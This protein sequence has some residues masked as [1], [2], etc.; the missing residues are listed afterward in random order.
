MAKPILILEALDGAEVLFSVQRDRDQPWTI[1]GFDSQGSPAAAPDAAAT[2]RINRVVVYEQPDTPDQDD[3]SAV[4]DFPFVPGSTSLLV[5]ARRRRVAIILDGLIRFFLDDRL[6]GWRG[7][8]G[9]HLSLSPESSGSTKYSPLVVRHA[10]IEKFVSHPISTPILLKRDDLKNKFQ[11]SGGGD[12]DPF[13][14]PAFGLPSGLVTASWTFGLWSTAPLDRTPAL[15]IEVRLDAGYSQLYW[16]GLFRPKASTLTDQPSPLAVNGITLVQRPR[17]SVEEWYGSN[18]SRPLW[19]IQLSLGDVTEQVAAVYRDFVAAP[20]HRASHLVKDGQPLSLLP[21]LDSIDAN[22]SVVW[23]VD[24]TIAGE[25]TTF[26]PAQA[27]SSDPKKLVW[28]DD[29]RDQGAFRTA[30][31]SIHPAVPDE[32]PPPA[33]AQSRPLVVARFPCFCTDGRAGNLPAALEQLFLL[34]P[35][36][37]PEYQS[38]L[39]VV[40]RLTAVTPAGGDGQDVRLGALRLSFPPAA[41]AS[42]TTIAGLEDG[43]VRFGLTSD[44]LVGIVPVVYECTLNIGLTD[45][46]PSGQDPLPGEEFADLFQSAGDDRDTTLYESRFRREPPLVVEFPTDRSRAGSQTLPFLL[47]ARETVLTAQSQTV[48]L[49]LARFESSGRGAAATTGERHRLWV[50]DRQPFLIAEIRFDDFLADLQAGTTNEIANF[51][52]RSGSAW[53]MSAAA[54]GFDLVLPPQGVG[55]AAEKYRAVVDPNVPHD[56]D[57]KTLVAYRFTP[58]AVLRVQPSYYRQRF[59]EPPWNLRRLLGYP[60][61]R[62]PGMALDEIRFELLYGLSG[63]VTAKGL[64]LAELAARLGDI[65]GR[66]PAEPLWRPNRDQRQG[67]LRHREAWSTWYELIQTRLSVL[68]PWRVGSAGPDEPDEKDPSKTPGLALTDGVTYSLRPS[69][70]LAFPART[71]ATGEGIAA[72]LSLLRQLAPDVPPRTYVDYIGESDLIDKVGKTVAADILSEAP[73]TPLPGGVAW[74][75]ESVNLY[76]LFWSRPDADA[77]AL[78]RPYFSSLG[79]WGFQKATFADGQLRIYSDTAM[80]RT[81]SMTLEILG[82]I[83]VTWHLAKLVIVYERTVLPT[84]QFYYTETNP[85]QNEQDALRGRPVLRKVKE[86][87]ELIEPVRQFPDDGSAPVERGCV[88][89]VGFPATGLR[90][91]VSSRWGHDVGKANDPDPAAAEGWKVPLWVP[92]AQPEDV[93]P[94]PSLYALF[95]PAQGDA[96][97]SA[98]IRDPQKLFFFTNTKKGRDPDPHKWPPVQGIDFGW[99][100][101]EAIMAP[102]PPKSWTVDGIPESGTLPADDAVRG[103]LGPFTFTL[104]PVS[105]AVD[106]MAERVAQPVGAALRNVT[107][108]R[109]YCPPPPEVVKFFQDAGNT[110]LVGLRDRVDAGLAAAREWVGRTTE[111]IGARTGLDSAADLIDEL[112]DQAA[113]VADQVKNLKLPKP[114]QLCDRLQAQVRRS[115]APVRA[116][117]ETLGDNFARQTLA[118]VDQAIGP[119]PGNLAA[120]IQKLDE[121]TDNL[122]DEWAGQIV[123]Q[124][125]LAALNPDD[126]PWLQAAV[127]DVRAAGDGIVAS[128]DEFL[129]GLQDLPLAVA[130]AATVWP[131]FVVPFHTARTAVQDGLARLQDL[132]AQVT[133]PIVGELASALRVSPDV[134]TAWQVVEDAARNLS[135]TKLGDL[136]AALDAVDQDAFTTALNNDIEGDIEAARDA[137][138]AAWDTLVVVVF[139]GTQAVSAKLKDWQAKASAVQQA[140]LDKAKD[141]WSA[142]KATLQGLKQKFTTVTEFRSALQR[143]LDTLRNGWDGVVQ[144]IEDAAADKVDGYCKD[145]LANVSDYI[146]FV[147]WLFGRDRLKEWAAD[148][149]KHVPNAEDVRRRLAGLEQELNNALRGLMDRAADGLLAPLAKAVTAAGNSVFR[150]IRAFGEAP[151]VPGLDFRLPDFQLATVTDRLAHIGYYFSQLDGVDLGRLIPLPKVDIT[152]VLAKAN[153]LGRDVLNALEIKLPTNQLFDR[154]VPFDLQK[155]DL[156]SIFPNFAGLKLDDLFEGLK[157]PATATDRVRVTH[158]ADPQSLRGWVQIDAD[159]PFSDPVTLFT[160]AGVQ[161]RILGGRFQATSRIEGGAGQGARQTFRGTISGDWEVAVGGFTLVTITQTALRFDDSGRITFDVR[162]DNVRLPGPMAWLAD[163]ISRFNFADQGFSFKVDAQG[164]HVV[165]DL[166]LPNIQAGTFGLAN[167]RLGFFFELAL[168]QGSGGPQFAITS[169][170]NVARRQAPFTLTVFILGGA[171]WFDFRFHYAPGQKEL[172][173][174]V[175][176]GILASASLAISLGPVSGGVYAY[177]GVVVEYSA[178]QGQSADLTV[179]L[180]IMFNGRLSVLGIVSVQLEVGLDADYSTGG[181]LLGRGHVNVSIPICWCFTLKVSCSVSYRFG[182]SGGSRALDGSRWGPLWRPGSFVPDRRPWDG[183]VYPG[184]EDNYA[185]RAEMFVAMFE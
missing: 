47:T 4:V 160:F 159:V 138:K 3:K 36:D 147:Q 168:S 19:L 61:E 114:D 68:E 111:V 123:R 102:D 89:G 71:T 121:L 171:G 107:L 65:P 82:R 92:G 119:L 32:D 164:V 48:D 105:Q 99:C 140:L 185:A 53:E 110:T 76:N 62:E 142:A 21:T 13:V 58:P 162:P 18:A 67:Y 87:V 45:V 106:V 73:G 74:P 98:D 183:P 80:G 118:R 115:F 150:L 59:A 70:R 129:D 51:S 128:I 153:E 84:R 135:G 175:T 156:R 158:G 44:N 95:Q 16:S 178:R 17:G 151:R 7:T 33:P 96:T 165:L 112:V 11:T 57:E 52:T 130:P 133:G 20:I 29:F 181:G 184:D 169:G 141:E 56:V 1:R 116:A 27:G 126:W 24:F 79:G 40:F 63:R 88:L 152:P 5:E 139:D 157:L 6:A 85:D 64:R 125:P 42:P 134:Q 120:G 10:T 50:I 55:E 176:V 78:H 94:R 83:S 108:M 66:Q 77:G 117:A 154:L 39:T 131:E 14:I 177:F 109:G 132:I 15:Q 163:L 166:P 113:A 30:V 148:V 41:A 137:L 25:W 167:L 12:W 179:S 143:E 173:A 127:A 90:I 146:G 149:L 81:H 26:Q 161:V 101:A 172:T 91:N 9:F 136:Q 86:Y 2:A 60:A 124:N 34:S 103:G 93:Y 49:I 31:G 97:V 180:V 43:T 145:L 72:D 46:G 122:F 104:G 155:F 100:P 23:V 174:D 22:P 144:R 54:T 8:L 38:V 37:S 69:A 28:P 75:F 170:A 35:G 182:R